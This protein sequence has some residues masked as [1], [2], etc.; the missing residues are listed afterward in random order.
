LIIPL[1]YTQ[2]RLERNSFGSQVS[3][4][5]VELRTQVSELQQQI[6]KLERQLE[7]ERHLNTNFIWN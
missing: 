7:Q 4:Q 5:E 6:S 3:T 1:D 2:T